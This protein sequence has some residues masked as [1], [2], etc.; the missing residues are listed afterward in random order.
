MRVYIFTA[1]FICIALARAE[2]Q[3]ANWEARIQQHAPD[4]YTIDPA[5]LEDAA[6]VGRQARVVPGY[7][8]GSFSGFKLFAIRPGSLWARLGLKNGDLVRAANGRRL[9]SPQAALEVW[10]TALKTG[11][12][13]DISRRGA[14]LQIT[15][16]VPGQPRPVAPPSLAPLSVGAGAPPRRRRRPPGVL[17]DGEVQGRIEAQ[18]S[19]ELGAGPMA[20][21]GTVQVKGAAIEVGLP[22]IDGQAMPRLALG[23]VDL[24]LRVAP[25][26]RG[27][28]AQVERLT[29][30]G[31]DLQVQTDPA[32]HV[33]FR[34]GGGID[35][36]LSLEMTVIPGAGATGEALRAISAGE[37]LRIVCR[38]RLSHPRCRL[39]WAKAKASTTPKS[40]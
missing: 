6:W 37:P 25:G 4:H 38:G 33:R 8:N 14:P 15:Y 26:P 19:L 9:D 30:A 40:P 31:A 22:A 24:R 21:S 2:A 23:D 34:P 20:V 27:A 12:V 36:Q 10:S 35:G 1:M 3:P 17:L 11:V 39:R 7:D 18:I 13:L 29:V 5:L 32:S 16:S 28:V